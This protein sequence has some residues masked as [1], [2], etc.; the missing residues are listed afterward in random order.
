M[1]LHRIELG[2]T[3]TKGKRLRIKRAIP[4][5]PWENF[6]NYIYNHF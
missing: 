5:W 4:K 3:D 6:A 1:A 2:S